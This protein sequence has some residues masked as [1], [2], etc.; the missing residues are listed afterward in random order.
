[1][2]EG[3]TITMC[4]RT[5]SSWQ[6]DTPVTLLKNIILSKEGFTM[7]LCWKAPSS[8]TEGFTK[9]FTS[10]HGGITAKHCFRCS[11][12]TKHSLHCCAYSLHCYFMLL[13]SLLHCCAIFFAAS[14]PHCCVFTCGCVAALH[15]HFFANSAFLCILQR[16][17]AQSFLE[18][19]LCPTLQIYAAVCKHFLH[20]LL[21]KNFKLLPFLMHCC[22]YSWP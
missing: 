18:Q 6:R 7:T 20:L 9:N 14:T 13:H 5:P 22:P 12:K 15:L 16:Q 19:L 8:L 3:F 11:F 10:S 4:W 1:M 17:N 2:T 21:S